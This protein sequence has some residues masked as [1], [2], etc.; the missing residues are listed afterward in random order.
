VDGRADDIGAAADGALA[1]ADVAGTRRTAEAATAAATTNLVTARMERNP[2]V[3][4]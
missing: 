4:F 2:P 1:V 3:E